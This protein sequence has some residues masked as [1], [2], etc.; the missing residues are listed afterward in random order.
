[1]NAARDALA[2][3]MTEKQLQTHVMNALKKLGWRTYHTFDSRKS[4]A[5]FP[6]IIALRGDRGLAIELKA[7]NHRTKRERMQEQLAWLV[8][9]DQAGFETALWQPTHWLDNTILEALAP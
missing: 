3:A 9:F 4:A 5:G 8:A 2:N 6:D 1:M 7:E